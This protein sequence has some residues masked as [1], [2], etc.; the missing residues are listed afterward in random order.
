VKINFS[1]GVTFHRR[2]QNYC[3]DETEKNQSHICSSDRMVLLAE[4]TVVDDAVKSDRIYSRVAK[5]NKC[6]VKNPTAEN[7]CSKY[8]YIHICYG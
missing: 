1:S 5:F 7:S 3:S 8:E 2:L 4:E 6:P